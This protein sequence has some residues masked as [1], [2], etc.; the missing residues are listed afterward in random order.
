[1]YC[2]DMYA[3]VRLFGVIMFEQASSPIKHQHAG[4]T[5]SKQ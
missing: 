4:N 1:M 5:L 2:V 3:Q